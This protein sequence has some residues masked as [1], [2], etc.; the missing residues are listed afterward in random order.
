MPPRLRTKL[1]AW[2]FTLVGAMLVAS[3]GSISGQEVWGLVLYNHNDV[4][5][6]VATVR[7]V[8]PY[9]SVVAT[10]LT[11]MEGRFSVPIPADGEYSVHVEHITAFGMVDGPLDLSTTSRPFVT[12]HLVP[13]P[14][15]LEA[16]TVMVEGRSLP[17]VRTGFYGREQQG[18]G[19]FMD[20]ADV[21]RRYPIRTSD[22]LRTIPGVQYIQANGLAGFSGYP[23]MSYAL[24]SEFF[25][26]RSMP[27]F[28]RVYVD[29]VVMEQGGKGWVPTMGFDDLV[30]AHEVSGMEVYRS[31]AETPP[32]FGGLNACGVILLWTK[33]GR[34]RG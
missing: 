17:L 25:G 23:V 27:C 32:Q 5:V 1:R 29:G 10:A 2:V 7:L 24:R 16:I 34:P 28:P 6:A 33:S 21:E 9:G 31:P 26:T 13:Q 20:L 3:A 4:P 18:L 30:Q 22:L 8:D 19:F 12:F 11:D 15:A 14:I